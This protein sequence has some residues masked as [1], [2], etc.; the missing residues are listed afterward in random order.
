M[1]R[2]PHKGK[3]RYV[4]RLMKLGREA[5]ALAYMKAHGLIQDFRGAPQYKPVSTS[6]EHPAALTQK[7]IDDNYKY[8]DFIP[9]RD[10]LPKGV[11]WAK[12]KREL[13]HEL[14]KVF[15]WEQEAGLPEHRRHEFLV[16]MSLRE[17]ASAKYR[18][19]LVGQVFPV[20][21][22]PDERQGGWRIHRA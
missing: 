1:S 4:V 2:P 12:C 20:E 5:D 13:A 18:G 9:H 15:T 17:Q 22:N 14:Q 8:P 21:P 16:W 7:Q 10:P 3:E 19:R 6:E 11:K